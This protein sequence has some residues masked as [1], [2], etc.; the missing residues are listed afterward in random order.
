M[1]REFSKK[2]L[3]V[4]G[5][6]VLILCVLFYIV[7]KEIKDKNENI[8]KLRDELLF[9]TKKQ[10]Y[11]IS[12]QKTIQNAN[13]DISTI[14]NS[15]VPNDGDVKFIEDLEKMAKDNKLSIDISSLTIEDS[16]LLTK[17][18]LTILRIKAN[19]KGG[20]SGTY[21]F[22]AEIEAL[23]FK[24][25]IDKFSLNNVKN[26]DSPEAKVPAVSTGEWQSSIEMRVLKYK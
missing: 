16:S 20:W 15:I 8:S 24:V 17:N 5:V 19:I 1:N 6:F 12:M 2:K 21:V 18:S 23:P 10:D 26:E 25:K 7:F 9:Q 13:S 3:I 22:L 14:N 11:M 4:P